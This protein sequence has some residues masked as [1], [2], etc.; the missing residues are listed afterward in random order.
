MMK[1]SKSGI[2]TSQNQYLDKP[3]SGSSVDHTSQTNGGDR[4]KVQTEQ[5]VMAEKEKEDRQKQVMDQYFSEQ[6]NS[7]RDF[8]SRVKNS[9]KNM[10]NLP[11]K[12]KATPDLTRLAGA[13]TKGAVH[14]LIYKLKSAINKLHLSD[15]DKALAKGDINRMKGV[16][17]KAQVKIAKLAG[18]E[19]VKDRQI[20]AEAMQKHRQASEL[21]AERKHVTAARKAKERVQ[22]IDAADFSNSSSI[23]EFEAG[24]DSLL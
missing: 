21:E 5:D 24:G 22:S 6:E 19:K 14:G 1:I 4:N 8:N 23:G 9:P 2:Q 17:Q 7:L 10:F 15:G 11:V 12:Y 16:L 13:S 18:E 20:L 3:V